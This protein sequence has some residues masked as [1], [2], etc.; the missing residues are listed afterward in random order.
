MGTLLKAALMLLTD[1]VASW[2]RLWHTT[3]AAGRFTPGEVDDGAAG[4][5]EEK[6]EKERGSTQ[7][8]VW[9]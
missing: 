4:G 7:G 1:W 5:E 8:L 6:Q 3:T 9:L 2:G